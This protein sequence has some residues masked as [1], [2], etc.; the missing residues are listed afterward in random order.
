[1][2]T[3]TFDT[4][5]YAK[6]L[7]EA[8]FTEQQAEI[9]AE[10]IREIIENNLATKQDILDFK[11][12]FQQMEGKLQQMEERLMYKLTIRLGLMLAASITIIAAIIKL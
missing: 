4:L 2:T 7:K 11:K 6:K 9:Q 12:D 8:G 1:V 10:A 3:T 5:M